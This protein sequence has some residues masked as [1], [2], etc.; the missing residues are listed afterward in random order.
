MFYRIKHCTLSVSHSVETIRMADTGE[1][2]FDLTAPI[3]RYG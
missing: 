2:A 3:I 1:T